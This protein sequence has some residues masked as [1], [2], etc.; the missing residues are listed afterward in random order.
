[1][2]IKLD[3]NKKKVTAGYKTIYLR[4]DIIEAIDKIA[5]ENN[6]SFNNI[7]VNMVEYC[8]KENFNNN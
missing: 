1:M 7:I 2:G 4:N 6:T 8:L 5:E 3:Y